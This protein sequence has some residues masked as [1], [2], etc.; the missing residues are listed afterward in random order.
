[1]ARAKLV[2]FFVALAY[3]EAGEWPGVLSWIMNIDIVNIY[4]LWIYCFLYV[5]LTSRLSQ[6]LSELFAC[7]FTCLTSSYYFYRRWMRMG[8]TFILTQMKGLD[9]Q[10]VLFLISFLCRMM[11]RLPSFESRNPEILRSGAF[12]PKTNNSIKSTVVQGSGISIAS[13]TWSRFEMVGT[14]CGLDGRLFLRFLNVFEDFSVHWCPLMK[15]VRNFNDGKDGYRSTIGHPW[16]SRVNVHS[17]GLHP[18]K[19]RA[20][21]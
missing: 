1:M 6:E 18:Q 15:D 7:I 11:F 4:D 3:V 2:S 17:L 16:T 12:L 21:W 8:C 10:S 20:A 5:F 13:A 9:I 14:S 19:P